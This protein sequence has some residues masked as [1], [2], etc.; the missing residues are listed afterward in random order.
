MTAVSLSL[1]RL[2]SDLQ[3]AGKAPSTIQQYL[4]SVRHFEEFLGR[5]L[6]KADQDDVRRWVDHLRGLPIG[7]QRLRWTGS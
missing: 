5:D 6:A 2:E 3:M 4:A 1:F 7:S